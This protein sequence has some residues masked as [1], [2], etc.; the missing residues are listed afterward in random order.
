MVGEGGQTGRGVTTSGCLGLKVAELQGKGWE[1]RR[2]GA[3]TCLGLGELG[4]RS[5]K[6]GGQN[7]WVSVNMEAGRIGNPNVYLITTNATE[8]ITP[9]A[10]LGLQHTRPLLLKYHLSGQ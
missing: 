1:R 9:T 7:G 10:R 8:K 5:D 4:Y 2:G 3:I 6:V